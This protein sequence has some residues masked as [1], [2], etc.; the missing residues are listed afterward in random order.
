MNRRK[1]ILS[2][3]ML[4][5][6]S[7]LLPRGTL[8]SRP[9]V[10]KSRVVLART[11]T[12]IR[13]P[14]PIAIGKAID[15]GLEMLFDMPANAAWSTLFSKRD[16][17]GLKV[18]CLAGKGISTHPVIVEVIS[19]RLQDIGLPPGNIIIWDRLN[20]DLTRGGFTIRLDSHKVRCLGNDVAGYSSQL[21]EIGS[22]CS[23]LSRIV[24][25]YC[26]AIINLPVLK[27]HGIV[28]ISGGMKN[29]FGAIDNPN[30]YHNHT[31]DPYVADV[32]RLPLLRSKTRLTICDGITAQYEG[33]PPY[34]PQWCWPLQSLIL[35][36][37]VVALDSIA[38][39]II[40]DKR[41][42][43]HMPS[44]KDAGREP[45]YIRSAASAGL[46]VADVEKIEVL[47]V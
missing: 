10:Q 2:G 8:L 20:D 29:Y 40:E 19:E 36:T 26:T 28:G 39:K 12:D 43:V 34:M 32:N 4:G 9:S 41:K 25:E 45:L 17:V 15:N 11:E 27:D 21:Y 31:G 5:A 22:V 33:G 23:R 37:D 16:V 30:K 13:K 46:G 24:T 47:S 44:L 3:A 14:D 35:A 1:F 6:G 42:Q 7:C 18:N 38:W